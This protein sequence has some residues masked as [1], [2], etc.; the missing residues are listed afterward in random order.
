MNTMPFDLQII[1]AC[2]FVRVG[3]HGEFD[4][5]DTRDVLKT[6]AAACHK[7]GIERAMFDVRGATSNLTPKDLAE[8]VSV[9]A[10]TVASKRLRLA[11]LHTGDQDYRTKLFVFF[12]AMR[13]RK[14]Q[15]F[16]KFED[17]LDWLS[18]SDDSAGKSGTAEHEVPIRSK[19]KINVEDES[20]NQ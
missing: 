18:T 2:E 8:L 11:I 14:V 12:S 4:L 6:L 3:A 10:K 15:G 19:T 17:G 20:S 16:E 13:G 7:R 5:E 1:R 9:F